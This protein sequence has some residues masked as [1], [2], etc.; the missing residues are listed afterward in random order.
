MCDPQAPD[1]DVAELLKK[2]AFKQA[3]I[4]SRRVETDLASEPLDAEGKD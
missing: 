2:S 1:P 4:Q 3:S